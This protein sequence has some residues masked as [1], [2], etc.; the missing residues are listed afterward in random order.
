MNGTNSEQQHAIMEAKESLLEHL[1][2]ETVQGI[3]PAYI[4]N[5]A[6][7]YIAPYAEITTNR[8]IGN[9]VTRDDN[10]AKRITGKF[11]STHVRQAAAV[12]R[13]DKPGSV[14]LSHV[15]T[16]AYPKR[17]LLPASLRLARLAFSTEPIMPVNESLMLDYGHGKELS[18]AI[19]HEAERNEVQQGRFRV[20]EGLLAL[21]SSPS[22]LL[23][24]PKPF[25]N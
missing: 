6:F 13:E 4:R 1:E 21:P 23:P 16:G 3:D 18:L 9:I 17:R 25:Q 12:Q 10:E 8:A 20:A 2:S 11:L 19:L 22:Y 7:A 14:Y 5:L 24:V 15:V